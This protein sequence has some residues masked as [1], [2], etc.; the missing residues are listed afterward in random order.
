M[1]ELKIVKDEETDL[2]VEN[3]DFE[4][5]DNNYSTEKMFWFTIPLIMLISI[6]IFVLLLNKMMSKLM[7]NSNDYIDLDLSKKTDLGGSKVFHVSDENKELIL[8]GNP[9][10]RIIVIRNNFYDKLV[11]SGHTIYKKT[12]VFSNLVYETIKNI[13]D[14]FLNMFFRC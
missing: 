3:L 12:K 9:D 5:E 13:S 2:S 1:L 14:F 8:K 11:Q 10:E 6:V 4:E 7:D